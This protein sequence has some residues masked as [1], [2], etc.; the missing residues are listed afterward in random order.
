MQAGR[1][2]PPLALTTI[3]V[4][5][6]VTYHIEAVERDLLPAGRDW[7]FIEEPN[8]DQHFVMANDSTVV[9][10]SDALG[11]I[12]QQVCEKSDLPLHIAS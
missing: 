9:L 3:G 4:T 1:G 12:I 6:A 2:D 8:G 11:E 10:T 5:R 7:F